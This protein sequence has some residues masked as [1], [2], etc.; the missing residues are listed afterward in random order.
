[1]DRLDIVQKRRMEQWRGYRFTLI[2]ESWK[3][4]VS[5]TCI[6]SFAS[7]I[8]NPEFHNYCENISPCS[9]VS[10]IFPLLS[11][12]EPC[13]S[14]HSIV[15]YFWVGGHFGFECSD[16]EVFRYQSREVSASWHSH[17]HL[18]FLPSVLWC[19]IL[20][21]ALLDSRDFQVLWD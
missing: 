10:R 14:N 5:T 12:T 1:M 17:H 6:S 11:Q 20:T 16:I 7:L 8:G 19:V 3:F 4:L 21:A 2:F 15:R 9:T 18:S 13:D